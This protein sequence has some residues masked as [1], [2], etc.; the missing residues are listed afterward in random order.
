MEN[1]DGLFVIRTF[2]NELNARLAESVLEA[3]GIESIVVGDDSSGWQPY[4]AA[5]HPFRLM[6]KGDD[7]EDAVAILGTS[8]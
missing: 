8:A 1:E 7:V 5:L 3:N 4:F 2:A 6:V